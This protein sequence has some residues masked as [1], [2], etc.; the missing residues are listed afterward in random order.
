M[1]INLPSPIND[2]TKS[3][4]SQTRNFISLYLYAQ[5]TGETPPHFH[6]WMGISL[7]AAVLENRVWLMKDKNKMF[8]NLYT[9]LVGGGTTGKGYAI[10]KAL[11]L[12]NDSGVRIRKHVGS[13]TYKDII[14][15]LGRTTK[16]DIT[17]EIYHP[18]PKLWLVTEE[19]SDCIGTGAIAKSFIKTMTALYTAQFPVDEGTRTHGRIHTKETPCL[20]WSAGSVQNWLMDSLTID[21]FLSGFSARIVTVFGDSNLEDRHWEVKF[22]WDYGQVIG[23]LAA[24]LKLVSF[25]EG[26]F[27]MTDGALLVGKRW[28]YNRKAPVDEN[29]IPA[30]KRA[31]S[32]ALKLAMIWSIADGGPLVITAN[33][34]DR[35]L[36]LAN[37]IWQGT[38]RLM[39]VAFQTPE[40]KEVSTLE[41]VL[42]KKGTVEHT[43]LSRHMR[44]KG[45]S[46]SKLRKAMGDLLSEKK[47]KFDRSKTGAMVYIWV[48]GHK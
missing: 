28:Y 27:T 6:L 11:H 2:S 10:S 35:G 32:L 39:E 22:P 34:M 36:Q 46:A 30:W 14:D 1:P 15:L 45:M 23:H 21:A 44:K 5:G 31:Q 18:D 19:M 26:E 40:T 24:R 42:M 43:P 9:F 37:I 3:A 33:H 41:K 17:G 20:N 7:L 47:V 38:I 13:T 8:P 25:M 4:L 29:L 16:D 12:L 48:G